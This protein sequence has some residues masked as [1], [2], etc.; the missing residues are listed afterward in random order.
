MYWTERIDGQNNT[1]YNKT[2]KET[3]KRLAQYYQSAL[4]KIQVELERLYDQ[5]AADGSLNKTVD[6]YRYDRFYKMRNGL[7]ELLTYEGVQANITTSGPAIVA[8]T[9]VMPGQAEQVLRS[10]WC[11]DG[12]HWSERVWGNMAKLQDSIEQGLI[13]CVVT[14]QSKDKLVKQLQKQFGVGFNQADRIVRTE[15]SYIQNQAAADRY[16]A[17]GFD[18]YRILATLDARTSE[19]CEEQN[20]KVYEF[21]K[22]EVG[23]NFPPFHPNCRTTIVPVIKG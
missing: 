20:K 11:A 9:F 5:L 15:L 13:D 7:V 12:K 22:M 14:G 6:L 8:K 23:V 1:L 16:I 18:R 21:A 4:A 3:D 19:I 10:V 17:A 2:Q